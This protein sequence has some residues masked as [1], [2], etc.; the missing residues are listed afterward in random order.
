M[1]NGRLYLDQNRWWEGRY[2]HGV[3][4]EFAF[5]TSADANAAQ[6][7]VRARI[8]RDQRCERA[9]DTHLQDN[10]KLDS[11]RR[12][13]AGQLWARRHKELR[14]RALNLVSERVAP[15]EVTIADTAGPEWAM[16]M[17]IFVQGEPY[18]VLCPVA[19]RVSS[20]GHTLHPVVLLAANEAHRRLIAEQAAPDQQVE[21]VA[22]MHPAQERVQRA[23]LPGWHQG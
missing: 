16:G 8:W 14:E 20:L 17:P 2:E 11:D 3:R 21:V 22:W 12:K 13:I 4:W 15:A 6:E 9:L 19:G 18:A 10:G 5:T 23:L 1:S 7:E